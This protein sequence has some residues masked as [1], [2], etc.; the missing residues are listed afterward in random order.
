[1]TKSAVAAL[2]RNFLSG[3]GGEWDWDDFISIPLDDAETD[4]IRIQC[5][6]LPDKY[7]PQAQGAYC[8]EEGMEVL[9]SLLRECE[10]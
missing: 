4:K 8:S 9:K 1:M 2:L 5:A 3:Q 6:E 7:P 10:S